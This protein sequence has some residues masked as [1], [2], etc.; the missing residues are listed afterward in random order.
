MEEN[1]NKNGKKGTLNKIL[2]AVAGVTM[3]ASLAGCNLQPGLGGIPQDNGKRVIDNRTYIQVANNE[4]LTAPVDSLLEYELKENPINSRD[5]AVDNGIYYN[6]QG[7]LIHSYTFNDARG[8][9]E[10][11][12]DPK[13]RFTPGFSDVAENV[14]KFTSAYGEISYYHKLS[15]EQVDYN[16]ATGEIL[17]YT[18]G[19]GIT[20]HVVTGD[21]ITRHVVNNY[22]IEIEY[23]ETKFMN[24]KDTNDLAIGGYP[25]LKNELTRKIL[26]N[27]NGQFSRAASTNIPR[28]KKHLKDLTGGSDGND[29]GEGIITF[30]PAT[31]GGEVTTITF[32]D[33]VNRYFYDFNG[34]LIHTNSFGLEQFVKPDFVPGIENL[35]LVTRLTTESGVKTYYDKTTGE[36]VIFNEKTGEYAPCQNNGIKQTFNAQTGRVEID[37]SGRT[38]QQTA[39][40]DMG[41]EM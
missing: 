16:E 25:L 4:A 35:S 7:Q 11:H 14:V 23:D 9:V 5:D 36:Q 31:I 41:R 6:K 13:K 26:A 3:A 10:F 18:A 24:R 12:V 34:N 39:Q 37:A 27:N 22:K 17:D 15:G 32:L 1:K 28:E 40:Q 8:T 2:G 30:H 20:R 21:S 19:D 38:I 33:K 29:I